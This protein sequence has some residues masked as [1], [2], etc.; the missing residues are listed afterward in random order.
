MAKVFIKAN[1]NVWN[2]CGRKGST[3]FFLA[4]VYKLE[5]EGK[6]AGASNKKFRE[7]AGRPDKST[8]K[9]TSARKTCNAFRT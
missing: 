7:R 2:S 6:Q 5:L 8:R 4:R 1:S 9:L 3:L